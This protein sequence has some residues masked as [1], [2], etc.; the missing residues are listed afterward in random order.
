MVTPDGRREMT[1]WWAQ[2]FS[3]QRIDGNFIDYNDHGIAYEYI[4]LGG[5][6]TE[7]HVYYHLRRTFPDGFTEDLYFDVESGLLHGTWPTSS[8]MSENPFFSYDYKDI[9]GIL[10]PH[11]NA[12]VFEGASPPHM[13][14]VEEA[15]INEDF[16]EDFFTRHEGK[17]IIE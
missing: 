10:F 9:G 7:R 1:A 6:E 14:V 15:R 11:L 12:R 2:S 16:G 3:H 5:F 8:H 13:M 4:G 17:P